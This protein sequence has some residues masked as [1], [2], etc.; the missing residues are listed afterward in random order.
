MSAYECEFEAEVLALALQGRWPDGAGDD[1]RA[2]ASHCSICAD[3]A[4]VAGAIEDARQESYTMAA[5]ADSGRVWRLA[6]LRARLEAAEAANRPLTAALVLAFAC[7]LGVLAVCLRASAAWFGAARDRV[8]AAVSTLDPGGWLAPAT[9]LAGEHLA[10]ALLLAAVVCV[11]PAAAYL[12][13]GR[14]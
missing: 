5:P 1:L 6:Q 11:I 9:N 3:V 7:A 13:L 14:D 10:L 8:M 12:A 4:V 2:H